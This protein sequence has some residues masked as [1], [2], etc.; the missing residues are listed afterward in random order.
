MGIKIAALPILLLAGALACGG[1]DE[2][3]AGDARDVPGVD[4]SGTVDTEIF[5]DS[6]DTAGVPVAGGAT[7]GAGAAPGGGGNGGAAA[8]GAAG[9]GAQG[10]TG[11]GTP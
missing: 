6:P 9:G 11:T 8:G 2:N 5:T 1:G 10:Q 4:A 7:G 3:N